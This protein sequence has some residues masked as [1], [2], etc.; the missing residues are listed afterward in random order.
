MSLDIHINPMTQFC[1]KSLCISVVSHEQDELVDSFLE[2]V[3]LW[4]QSDRLVVIVVRNTMK[5]SGYTFTRFPFSV[6]ILQNSRPKGFGANHNQ[7]FSMCQED[8]F[9]VI[10]PDILL[11]SD[12]FDQLI[13]LV[14]IEKVGIAAPVLV[15]SS[16]RLQD[17]ARLF[18]TPGRI[19]SRVFCR[20]G[21]ECDYPQ[22]KDCISPD[23]VAGMFM[24]FPS[25]VY[26]K[27]GGFDDRYFMYC[28]DADICMRLRT[29]GY[30]VLVN[31]QVSAVHNPRR[32]SHRSLMHFWWHLISLLRFF[33][34]Y[35]FYTL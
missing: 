4:C 13:S 18:P 31:T 28:E 16:G 25:H 22:S 12:P 6:T 21:V 9:C 7:A 8:F 19:I 30:K 26:E 14:S 27:I 2:S 10:N 33:L 5:P 17:S 24:V 35:P 29:R 11:T 3:S 32:S 15:D 1:N 34:R 20:R 23:W